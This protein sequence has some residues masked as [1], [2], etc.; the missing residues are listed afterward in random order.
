MH[1]RIL[2]AVALGAVATL[3]LAACAGGG[4]GNGG[5]VDGEG[6]ELTVWIMKGTN[7]DASA[8][9]DEVVHGLRRR[10]PAPRSRS[11][12]SSGPTPTTVS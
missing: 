3:G 4:T 2:P 11:R 6:Q 10:R 7:P 1:K 5:A 9:Y 8:F 12:R